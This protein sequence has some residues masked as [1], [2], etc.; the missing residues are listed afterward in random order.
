M[1]EPET[2]GEEIDENRG[3]GQPEAQGSLR[4]RILATDD[5]SIEVIDIP[6]WKEKIEVRSMSGRDRAR[7]VTQSVNPDTGQVNIETVYP[8]IVIA[9][10]HDP[11]TGRRIFRP[12]DR[13]ALNDKSSRAIDRIAQ[14]GLRLSG[15]DQEAQKRAAD[16]FPG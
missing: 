15:M 5:V 16:S 11:Q 14:V 7:L 1:N 13:D 3:N 2:M 4:D 8:D 9:T 10:A 12:Q 6:E